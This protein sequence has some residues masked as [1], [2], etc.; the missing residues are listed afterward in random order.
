MPH[1]HRMCTD[2][3]FSAPHL[4]LERVFALLI[5]CSIYCRLIC[6]VKSGT[7]L[8]RDKLK[9]VEATAAWCT[10]QIN[11][12]YLLLHTLTQ[13]A[14]WFTCAIHL[15]LVDHQ[16]MDRAT[17]CVEADCT[18]PA[19]CTHVYTCTLHK[20]IPGFRS[21]TSTR[22]CF[23][24]SLV[25]NWTYLSIGPSRHSWLVPYLSQTL[26]STVLFFSSIISYFGLKSAQGWW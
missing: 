11:Y 18:T 13:T 15:V 4:L 19:T 25:M 5:W 3:S 16:L 7:D 26:H 8:H 24:S 20:S 10:V 21:T 17:L 6:P 22:Q 12:I 23:L 1:T 9:R 2:V 14:Y